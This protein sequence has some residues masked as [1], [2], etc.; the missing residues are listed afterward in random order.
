[1]IGFAGIALRALMYRKEMDDKQPYD[2][3][4]SGHPRPNRGAIR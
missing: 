3:F 2:S 4:K 1:M